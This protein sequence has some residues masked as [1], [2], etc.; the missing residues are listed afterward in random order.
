[1]KYSPV[2]ARWVSLYFMPSVI[3]FSFYILFLTR[4]PHKVE[5]ID[6]DYN[7]PKFDSTKDPIWI[8]QMSDLHV[9]QIRPK[10][11]ERVNETIRYIAKNVNPLF[12]L[13]TG[14]LTDNLE[15]ESVWSPA[16]PRIDNFE[17]FKEIIDGAGIPDEKL[18]EILGNHDTWGRIDFPDLYRKFLNYKD[19]LDKNFYVQTYERNNVRIV[20]FQP[21]KFPTGHTTLHFII[22]LY[23]EELDALED[24]LNQPT[25]ADVTI[26]AMHF[27]VGMTC[28][29]ETVRSSR[30]K[31]NLREILSDPKYKIHAMIT[32]HTHPKHFD[33]V[34]FGSTIEITPTALLDKDG[35]GI[36]SIDN[37][38]INYNMYYQ[39]QTK[40]AI[41]TSPTPSQL[42]TRIFPD[43]NFQIRVVALTP[44]AKHF[45]VSG[46]AHG[47]LEFQRELEG[48]SALYAMNVTFIPGTY[49]I[50]I[51]GD[52]NTTCN[53]SVGVPV[54]P[55]YEEKLIDLLG[56]VIYA[57]FILASIYQIIVLI[58]MILPSSWMKSFRT[59]FEWMDGNYDKLTSALMW[60]RGILMGPFSLGR[61]LSRSSFPLKFFSIFIILS[62]YLIPTGI[63]LIEGKLGFFIFCGVY[64]QGKISYD[65]GGLMF[66]YFYIR[67][68]AIPF[69]H[70]FLLLTFNKID[71]S[72]I[73]DI[74]YNIYLVIHGIILWMNYGDDRALPLILRFTFQF[75]II[76]I[77]GVILFLIGWYLKMKVNNIKKEKTD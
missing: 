37:H 27:T 14:D 49:S 64:Y 43:E 65:V 74:V 51:S 6:V 77:V 25:D 59:Q 34:H 30:S 23:S 73:F 71:L 44:N 45:Y 31:R 53:F 15:R 66:G 63:Y 19:K 28:P 56:E 39:N 40:L 35:F 72:F 75:H 26:F 52:L 62:S 57:Y 12:T 13:L 61:F 2:L 5:K 9:T 50:T 4:R 16:Y 1:M 55:F 29:I 58:F 7:A 36:F 54:G 24:A 8:A 21:I 22:P 46:D 76:P 17:L 67:Y 10:V 33:Y 3:G 70:L 60:I 42:A 20:A 68:I 32:G 41:L 38:R 47:E 18:I 11:V 48:G 69:L